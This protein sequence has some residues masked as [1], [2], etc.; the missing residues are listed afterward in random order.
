MTP[1]ATSSARRGSPTPGTAGAAGNAHAP[2]TVG[3]QAYAY[4]ANG[5]VTSG[6]GRTYVWD[7][8]NRPTSIAGPDGVAE[9][10]GYDADGQ[11]VSRTRAGVTTVYLAGAWEQDVQSGVSTRTRAFVTLQGDRRGARSIS[12]RRSAHP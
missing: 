3:G 4:D 12:P 1:W 9:A 10:Y 6:G 8:N 11:R 5:N 7:A 2:A